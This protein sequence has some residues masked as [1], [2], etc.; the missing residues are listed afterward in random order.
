MTAPALRVVTS[1]DEELRGGLLTVRDLARILNVSERESYRIAER[2]PH[3]R[4]GR[5]L[6][7][8]LDEVLGAL[9][10]AGTS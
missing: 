4:V 5:M 8:D 7:F 2:V 10:E 1:T 3:Y 9:R 6:R